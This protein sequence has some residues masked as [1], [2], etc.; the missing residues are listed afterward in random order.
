M[1][2]PSVPRAAG[3]LVAAAQ[4]LATP[5]DPAGNLD[6]ARHWVGQAAAAG[7]DI[8]VLPELWPCGYD[9]AS[10]ASAAAAGAPP[11]PP[12][13]RQRSRCRAGGRRSSVPW[14]DV[15]ESGCSRA[16]CPSGTGT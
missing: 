1:T 2:S 12:P 13:R 7:A 16:A 6:A 9:V 4:W 15:M 3:L 10:L 5:G 8:V 14:R 11:P